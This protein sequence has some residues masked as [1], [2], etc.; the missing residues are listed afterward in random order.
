MK[1]LIFLVLVNGWNFA[2]AAQPTESIKDWDSAIPQAQ[3]AILNQVKTQ[4]YQDYLWED[5]GASCGGATAN[6]IL[7]D[8][9]T[10]ESLQGEVAHR[11]KLKFNVTQSKNYCQSEAL[12]ECVAP[13]TVYSAERFRVG[14][15]RCTVVGQ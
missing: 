11:L 6:Y 8:Y 2:I 10:F 9:Y 15:W 13:V 7:A 14:Q 12:L 4:A 5:E 3:A 1:A